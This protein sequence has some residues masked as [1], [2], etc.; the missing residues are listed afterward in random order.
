MDLSGFLEKEKIEYF[1][2]R[3]LSGARLIKPHLIEKS[4]V[5]ETPGKAPDGSALIFLVPY[6]TGW[7]RNLS[8]YALSRD[9][10][11]FFKELFGRLLPFLSALFPGYRFAGFSDSSPIAEVEAAAA[12]GLGVIGDNRLLINEKYSSLVF[13]GEVISDM[14]ANGWGLEIKT[15]TEPFKGCLHCGECIKSCP[16]KSGDGG[17]GIRECLSAI[18][19]KKGALTGEEKELIAK[20]GSVWG[21]DLCQKVCP[22]TAK[23]IES[24]SIYTPIRFFWENRIDEINPDMLSSMT[25]DEFAK[26]AYSWRG[27]ETI[28]RNARVFEGGQDGYKGENVKL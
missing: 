1:S 18:T 20:N 16:A 6:F 13:I 26:R 19:Q 28:L 25:E 4:G 15:N 10:H 22:Y 7:G 24:K 17:I 9:Y 8:A 14:P 23:A 5:F 27:R 11:L 2:P 21:C 3:P 12:A